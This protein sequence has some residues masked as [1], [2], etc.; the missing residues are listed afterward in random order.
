[1]FRELIFDKIKLPAVAVM[2]AL[3]LGLT[4]YAAVELPDETRKGSIDVTLTSEETG[5]EIQGGS[6]TLYKVGKAAVDDDWNYSFE[7]TDDFADSGVSLNSLEPNGDPGLAKMLAEYASEKNLQGSTVTVDDH[8]KARFTGLETGLYLLVQSGASNGYYPVSPFLVSVPLYD[9][10]TQ[11]YQYDDIDAFPK[12]QPAKRAPEFFPIEEEIVL[13][14]EH[15][16][17]TNSWVDR[18]S[19]NEYN[20]IEFEMTTQIPDMDPDDLAGGEYAML[21]HNELATELKLDEHEDTDI[22]ITVGGKA[23]YPDYQDYYHVEIYDR[24]DVW[25]IRPMALSPSLDTDDNICTFH[26][27]VDLSGLYNDTDIITDADLTG[28]T[29]VTV[30]FY[31]DLEGT[32]LN[33]TYLS[34]IQYQVYNDYSFRADP[35]YTSNYSVVEVYTFEIDIAKISASTNAPLADATFGVYYDEECSDPVMRYYT[36][37]GESEEYR[38]TSDNEGKAVFYGL[39]GGTYY[40]RELNAPNGYVLNTTVFPVTLSDDFDGYRYGLSIENKPVSDTSPHNG[41]GGGGGSG[42]GSGRGGVTSGGPGTGDGGSE[43]EDGAIWDILP[44]PQTGQGLALFIAICAM[45]AAGAG[46]LILYRVRRKE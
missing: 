37:S 24:H 16:A 32:D 10:K 28:N 43:G 42:S 18:A 12:T 17:D 26:V 30:Y 3:L 39:A 9:E 33:G 6:I 45:I 44:L 38:V 34:T 41:G 29:D 5:A 46:M 13:D 40:V 8:G 21:F 27:S 25:T 7:L 19:V 22:H 14:Q 1:M 36:V 11:T 15:E 4:A 2:L 23:L 35:V 31:A 20:A